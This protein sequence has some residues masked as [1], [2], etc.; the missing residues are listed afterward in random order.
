MQ[1]SQPDNLAKFIQGYRAYIKLWVTNEQPIED[2]DPSYV[3]GF[4]VAR[5]D[6]GGE[7]VDLGFY[8]HIHDMYGKCLYSERVIHY[9]KAVN[10]QDINGPIE[11]E[12]V[13]AYI[14]IPSHK[15]LI[16][17][18]RMPSISINY[19]DRADLENSIREYG[20]TP[21]L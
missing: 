14:L 10:G 12:S 9:S 13:P 2:K 21:K 19:R 16:F 20:L 8:P 3:A 5:E 6:M 4:D 7:F 18:G 1:N 17:N 11:A 15:V